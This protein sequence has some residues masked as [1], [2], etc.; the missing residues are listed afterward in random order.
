M[1]ENIPAAVDDGED[2]TGGFRRLVDDAIGSVEIS[3]ID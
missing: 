2:Q 3:R 1:P